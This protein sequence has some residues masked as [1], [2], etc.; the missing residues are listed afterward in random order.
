MP[1]HHAIDYIKLSAHNLPAAK[2]FYGDAVGWAVAGYS[3]T[4]DGIQSAEREA[5]TLAETEPSA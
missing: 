5:G 2:A 3:P 1:R 4:V